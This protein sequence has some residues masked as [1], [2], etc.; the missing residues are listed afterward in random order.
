MEE[1]DLFLNM[2]LLFVRYWDCQ[3]YIEVLIA[4]EIAAQTKWRIGR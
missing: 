3:D 1:D 4:C 2:F